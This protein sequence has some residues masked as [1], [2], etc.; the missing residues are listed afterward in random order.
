MWV[1]MGITHTHTH[2]HTSHT[3]LEESEGGRGGEGRR[4]GG[5]ERDLNEAGEKAFAKVP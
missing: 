4:E 3:F 1:C 5:R 2:T